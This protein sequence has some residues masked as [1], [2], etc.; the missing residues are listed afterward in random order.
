MPRATLFRSLSFLFLGGALQAATAEPGR[1]LVYV[2]NSLG[3]DLTVIDLASLKV[4][5]VVSVGE[6]PSCEHE[7]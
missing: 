4:A 6:H 3:S 1:T 2:D 7:P 5:G